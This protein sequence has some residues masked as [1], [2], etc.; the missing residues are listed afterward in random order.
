MKRLLAYILTMSLVVACSD[1]DPTPPSNT[2]LPNWGTITLGNFEALVSVPTLVGST[3]EANP[4]SPDEGGYEGSFEESAP[5]QPTP[6]E[7]AEDIDDPAQTGD[8][9][10][11]TITG[12]KYTHF[13]WEEGDMVSVFST[14][15]IGKTS[16]AVMVAQGSGNSDVKFKGNFDYAA[17]V[18]NYFALYPASADF[19]SYTFT[20]DYK[21]QDGTD[22]NA[23]LL[24]ACA[25]SAPKGDVNFYFTSANSLLHVKLTGDEAPTT[26]RT[27]RLRQKDG[28]PF[29]TGFTYDIISQVCQSNFTTSEE[30]LVTNPD[31]KGF[32]IALP[33]DTELS[34]FVLIFE[35]DKGTMG[36]SYK[37]Q[38]FRRATTYNTEVKWETPTLTCG[39]RSSYDYFLNDA[40]ADRANEM[41]N[42]EIILGERW[43]DETKSDAH[44]TYSGIQTSMITEA[45]V[46]ING[47]DYPLPYANGIIGHDSFFLLSIYDGI[48]WGEYKAKAYIETRYSGRFESPE[49]TIYVTGIP[50]RTK[51]DSGCYGFYDSINEGKSQFYPWS[52]VSNGDVL[53]SGQVQIDWDGTGG[54]WLEG[55]F[56]DPK[57]ASPKFHI[58][59]GVEIPFYITSSVDHSGVIDATVSVHIGNGSSKVEEIASIEL[60]NDDS[61]SL[62][63][64]SSKVF[65]F[66]QSNNR[67]IFHHEYGASGPR[68]EVEWLKVRY[69]K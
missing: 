34:N 35:S 39:A 33:P 5:I 61:Q 27:V 4:V 18:D 19:K 42:S 41:T 48:R 66:S 44:S 28:T 31:P 10:R 36:Y 22:E 32:F 21:T 53:D 9:T 49:K 29:N 58:P 13:E 2:D 30:I 23:A 40:N 59:S 3:G 11:V 52:D 17:D 50:Y 7:E 63:S 64:P 1:D 38:V 20:K 60:T 57:I 16:P 46:H 68:T 55:R 24:T 56:R 47:K 62:D 8:E 51:H 67:I 26:L 25:V 45:G 65:V 37:G 6:E 14:G 69:K 43:L 54:V 12:D 15:G